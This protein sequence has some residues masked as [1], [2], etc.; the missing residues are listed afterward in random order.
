MAT[1]ADETETTSLARRAPIE[2]IPSRAS[3]LHLRILPCLAVLTYD[4][5]LEQKNPC[6]RSQLGSSSL[7]LKW[8]VGIPYLK[9]LYSKTIVEKGTATS[10]PYPIAF[11]KLLES[12]PQRRVLKTRLRS[13][14]KGDSGSKLL[15]V[16]QFLQGSSSPFM[17]AW[18]DIET[19]PLPDE[20]NRQEPP[21]QAEDGCRGITL[22]QSGYRYPGLN[23]MRTLVIEREILIQPTYVTI[24]IFSRG[25]DN[26][27]EGIVFVAHPE[28]LFWKLRWGIFRLR[29]LSS[30][31]LSLR[32]V[33]SFR[34]Y[35]VSTLWR[36]IFR[37]VLTRYSATL[38]REHMNV[39]IL[40]RL[41][42]R[43][44]KS[45]WTCIRIGLSLTILH[46]LGRTGSTRR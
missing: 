15:S 33:K 4:T 23:F 16:I 11:R 40:T 19:G 37:S 35:R 39:F 42:P 41:G 1:P 44:C 46:W 22:H 2:F 29:G 12:Q 7:K 10:F 31:F 6:V 24:G 5:T 13:N 26:P 28:M 9:S 38:K 20:E 17:G 32:Q 8:E 34:L 25:H 18:Y 43:I 27:Q 30:T 14:N 45:F 36:R 21:A 3:H